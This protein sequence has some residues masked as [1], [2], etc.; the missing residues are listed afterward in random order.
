MGPVH[1]TM[2]TPDRLQLHTTTSREVREV[3]DE[4]PYP[5]ASK[6]P[7]SQSCDQLGR[8][9]QQVSTYL[10]YVLCFCT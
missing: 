5:G 6:L 2:G 4:V 1:T 3:G 10:L 9:L 7:E 8:Y